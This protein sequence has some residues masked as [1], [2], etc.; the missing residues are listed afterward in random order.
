MMARTVYRRWHQNP[1]GGISASFPSLTAALTRPP[2]L[3]PSHVPDRRADPAARATFRL[4]AYPCRPSAHS[5]PCGPPAHR[6]TWA[7]EEVARTGGDSDTGHMLD[8]SNALFRRSSFGYV[9]SGIVGIGA[10]A[11]FLL[12]AAVAGIVLFVLAVLCAL[13]DFLIMAAASN[14][15]RAEWAALVERA[16]ARQGRTGGPGLASAAPQSATWDSRDR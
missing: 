3:P 7:G 12:G 4:A 8:Q 2:G 1:L 15:S 16:L 5:A 9:A 14:R 13:V 10:V 11:A 6:P